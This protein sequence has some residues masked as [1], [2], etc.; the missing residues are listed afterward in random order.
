MPLSDVAALGQLDRVKR[1]TRFMTA[2]DCF[3]LSILAGPTVALALSFRQKEKLMALGEYLLCS[4]QRRHLVAIGCAGKVS[5]GAGMFSPQPL[6]G[7]TKPH[8]GGG[9][10]NMK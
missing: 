4:V 3:C 8:V 1:R 9:P 10:W 2:T 6:H 5:T 7:I